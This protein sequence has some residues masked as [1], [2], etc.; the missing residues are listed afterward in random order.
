MSQ[1]IITTE[2]SA[3]QAEEEKKGDQS[4]LPTDTT[5]LTR[6]MREGDPRFQGTMEG[7][8][9]KAN[10]RAR[11]IDMTYD[12]LKAAISAGEVTICQGID[13]NNLQAAITAER[14]EMGS[15][16]WTGLE[17]VPHLQVVPQ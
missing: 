2:D 6:V 1:R 15:T 9:L 4:Y 7:Y 8:T 14:A 5:Q 10:A 11:T 17:N 16:A 12:E 3:K 13:M